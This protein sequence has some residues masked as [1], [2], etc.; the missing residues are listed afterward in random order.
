ML[1]YI[2]QNWSYPPGWQPQL[3]ARDVPILLSRVPSMFMTQSTRITGSGSHTLVPESDVTESR[4]P[5]GD[6][7][8]VDPSLPYPEEFE[9]GRDC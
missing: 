2:L 6:A 8:T 5:P 4:E 9:V 7:R 1:N 3:I